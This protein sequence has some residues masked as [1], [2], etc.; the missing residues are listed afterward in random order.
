MHAANFTALSR[1]VAA[2]TGSVAFSLPVA[3][4]AGVAV[5]VLLLRVSPQPR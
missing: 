4:A 2:V 5:L 3:A 1:L